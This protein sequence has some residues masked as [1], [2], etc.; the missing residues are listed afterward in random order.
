MRFDLDP[1]A[2]PGPSS[3]HEA[4][5]AAYL[6]L[7]DTDR[8]AQE[9]SCPECGESPVCMIWV[10]QETGLDLLTGRPPCS[11]CRWRQER[12][13]PD[14]YNVVEFFPVDPDGGDDQGGPQ[15]A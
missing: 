2:R 4:A 14:A 1:D 5:T 7:S 10:D 3:P 15:A 12:F 13:R 8:E 6:T 11:E 9:G